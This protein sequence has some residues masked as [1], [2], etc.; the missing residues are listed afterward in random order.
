MNDA[1]LMAAVQKWCPAREDGCSLDVI[2]ATSEEAAALI[3]A[4][5]ERLN[6]LVGNRRLKGQVDH[7]MMPIAHIGLD[8]TRKFFEPVIRTVRKA[9]Q[10][11]PDV[12]VEVVDENFT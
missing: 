10:T 9:A 1:Q 3:D 6:R 11:A 4:N 8:P 12:T 7:K 5:R 2:A